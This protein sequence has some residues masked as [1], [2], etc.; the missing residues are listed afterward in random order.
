MTDYVLMPGAHYQDICQAVREKTGKEALLRSG[1]LADEIRGMTGGDFYDAFWDA[2]QQG[3]KRVNYYQRFIQDGWN[4]ETFQPKYPITCKGSSSYGLSVFY[5]SRMT[6]ISVPI[7]ITGVS[8]KEM[9][10]QCTKLVTI[11]RLV[12]DGVT[13]CTT[14]FSGCSLLQ[15]LNIEGSIDVNLSLSATAVLTDLS[16]QKVL[17]CL[18]QLPEGTT[19][20]LTLH[21]AVG[22]RLSEEQKAAVTAKNWE[23]VY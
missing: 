23:L 10:N 18:A 5:N 12:M 16:V 14:M 11:D 8:A 7:I 4:D 20:T 19:R 15:N 2:Y 17:N 1:E 9:F 6:R 3:G 22:S 13:D 21:N